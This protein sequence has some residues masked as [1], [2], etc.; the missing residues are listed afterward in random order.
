MLIIF[1]K[2]VLNRNFLS[3]VVNFGNFMAGNFLGGN[4]LGRIRN[5]YIGAVRFLRGL[6]MILRIQN[7]FAKKVSKDEFL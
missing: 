2:I 6:T 1:I 3:Y 5:K 7:Y 4:F